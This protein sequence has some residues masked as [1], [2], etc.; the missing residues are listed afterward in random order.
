MRF[1]GPEEVGAVA[2]SKAPGPS[3]AGVFAAG[4][5]PSDAASLSTGAG[6][7]VEGNGKSRY[8]ST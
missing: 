7:G 3:F 4:V 2:V 1:I 8:S 5:S 6:E